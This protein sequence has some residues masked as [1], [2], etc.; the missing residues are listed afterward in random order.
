MPRPCGAGRLVQPNNLF[1]VL[2]AEAFD[3]SAARH[4]LNMSGEELLC[5]LV[6]WGISGS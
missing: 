5:K 6:F 2:D 1:I 4:L 3:A